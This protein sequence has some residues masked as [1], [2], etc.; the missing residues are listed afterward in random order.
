MA[1]KTN[2]EVKV[3]IKTVRSMSTTQ[4]FIGHDVDSLRKESHAVSNMT[5]FIAV[6]T[7]GFSVI[8]F[9]YMLGYTSLAIP[10][11]TNLTADLAFDQNASAWFAVSNTHFPFSRLIVL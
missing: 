3:A 4:T 7:A 9:G 5:T 8:N 1:N 2:L 10:Q 11:L 6:A